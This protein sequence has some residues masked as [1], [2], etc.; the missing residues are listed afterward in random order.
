M[1]KESVKSYDLSVLDKKYAD[2]WVALSLDYKK[3]LAVG[4]SLDS[5]LRQAKRPDKMVLKVFP[6]TGYVPLGIL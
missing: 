5:I 2:K 4:D 6:Q 1:E 3:V